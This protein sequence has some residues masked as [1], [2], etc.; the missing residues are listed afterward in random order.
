MITI[1]DMK[2]DTSGIPEISNYTYDDSELR[3]ELKNRAITQIEA[4]GSFTCQFKLNRMVWAKLTGLWD[5]ARYNCP[6]KRV[7]HLMK[8]GK[9]D[10]IKWKNF[11]RAI[12][13]IGR[14][15]ERG[16]AEVVE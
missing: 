1:G 12:K 8:Y 10:R 9:N 5:W 13:M 7:K 2:I 16:G 14:I 6:D 3:Y 15:L 11:K 4:S